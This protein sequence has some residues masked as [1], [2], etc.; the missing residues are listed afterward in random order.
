MQTLEKIT[1]GVFYA[2]VVAALAT[3]LF[4]DN[5]F[6]FPFVSSKAFAFRL[7]VEVMVLAFLA[8]QVLSDRYRPR[9]SAIS[10][11][12]SA[13]IV[14]ATLASVLGGNFSGSFWGDMERSEGLILWLHLL[15]FLVMLPAVVKEEK[16]WLGLFDVSLAVGWLL[17]FFAVG[18]AL[19][20]KSVLL[21]SGARVEAT[22]GNAAFLAAYMIFHIAIAA[23]LFL[24]RNGRFYKSYYVL[25]A[26]VFTFVV[27][28]TATRGSLLGL[29]AGLVVTGVLTLW[30][31]QKRNI[32]L[33]G[34]GLLGLIVILAGLLYF[35][36]NEPWVA[37]SPRLSR[38]VSISLT[39][40][41]T[42]T[43]L[44][45]WQAAWTGWK[46]K[47]FLGHGLENFDIVFNRHFPPIIYEDAGSQVWFDRAHNLIF[48][49]GVTTGIAGL[50]IYLLFIFYP[51][52]KLFAL[53]LKDRASSAGAV[54]FIALV[55]AFFVQ[56]LFVFETITTYV[57]LFFVWA[58]FS[59]G[60]LYPLSHKTVAF[61]T[62]SW[63]TF[64]LVYAVLFVPLVWKTNLYP[65]KINIAAAH[66]LHS[67]PDE[68][69]FFVIVDRFKKAVLP[70][71]YGRQE[72]RLQFI[73]FVD[74]Q[75]VNVGPVVEEVRPVLAFVDEEVARLI[76][77]RPNDA[78]NLLLAMRHYN[79]TARA[80]P[81][82]TLERYQQA[83][84]FYQNLERLSPT[85]PHV[86]QEAGYTELYLFRFYNESQDAQ[87][88]AA[89]AA[90]AEE[91]FRKTIAIN[92]RV[93]ESYVNLL[94]L[95]FNTGNDSGVEKLI[96]EMDRMGIH[97][98][99]PGHLS[100][101]TSIARANARTRW[102][103][104]FSEQLVSLTPDDVEGWVHLAVYYAT[105]GERA[106]ALELAERIKAFG[107]DYVRQAEIFVE[108]VKA[109][110][111]EKP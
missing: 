95:Y 37:K 96:S 59:S 51:A 9:F 43:R 4:V 44:V 48:D 101:I 82:K 40:R 47:F 76:A 77:D 65:A 46:E 67:D 72:Y 91:Y 25:S 93:I 1:K 17:S 63:M 53:V 15:A 21:T 104:F 13:F 10:Y 54:I 7:A 29:A 58:F 97:W 61:S 30:V 90:R 84:D 110:K 27:Y 81:D 2:M 31:S 34:L 107:G 75:L 45:T 64:G 24:K 87:A 6:F 49:R 86:P 69:D 103:G 98:R 70:A 94:M 23:F 80:L 52:L 68:E 19:E 74:Q 88:A 66:A 50:V 35:S 109:G 79:F 3:P 83:L 28:A 14:V 42:E 92:P 26:A 12:A 60:I 8:L 11:L 33:L 108:S 39:D 111:Y 16:H 100:K 38:L 62:K 57:I 22:F 36:R 71:S 56:D 105:L 78:R 85:R 89:A 32:K 102:I 55:V 20:A 99:A 5:D 106:K 41:T 18:Q 73:E